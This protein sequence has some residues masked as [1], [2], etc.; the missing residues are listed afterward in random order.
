MAKEMLRE[1]RPHVTLYR[2][3]ANGI[4]WVEDGTTGVGHSAHPNIDASGSV[5]GMQE[6]GY[7]DKGARTVRSHGFIYNID[8]L[9]ANDDEEL[10]RIAAQH[11]QCGGEHGHHALQFTIE[12]LESHV[13]EQLQESLPQY[14][15]SVEGGLAHAVT[16]D[17]GP[18][19]ADFLHEHGVRVDWSDRSRYGVTTSGGDDRG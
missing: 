16:Q 8:K 13:W 2:D 11:C 3:T 12:Q 4:A 10:D 18:R 1:I 6:L 14:G 7:W 15:L 5:R 9:V 19:I 17:I